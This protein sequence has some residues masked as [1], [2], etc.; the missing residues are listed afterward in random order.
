MT[1]TTDQTGAIALDGRRPAPEPGRAARLCRHLG[2]Q[3]R[4]R[5]RRRH[6]G[7][8]TMP[9]PC[10]PS[11]NTPRPRP[12]WKAPSP[13]I[14]TSMPL[15]AAY[16]KALADAGRPRE[17]M[18]VLARAHTP[19]KPDWSVLSA[20]GA[21]ADQLGDH[22]GRRQL[23]RG[24]VEDPAG[25]AQ[26]AVEPRPVLRAGQ[27]PA[28][29]EDIMKLAAADPRADM[30]VRQNYALV[31]SLEG[32]FK[33]A[34]GVAATDL[35]PGDAAASV[36]A[37]RQMIAS[38]ARWRGVGQGG[39]AR[40]PVRAARDRRRLSGA[41]RLRRAAGPA[42]VPPR[43]APA[44]GGTGAGGSSPR[45]GPRDRSATGLGSWRRKNASLRTWV[46]TVQFTTAPAG[47]N[48]TSPGPEAPR[49]HHAVVEHDRAFEDVDR[50]VDVVLPLELARRA[51][52]DQRAGGPVVAARQYRHCGRR[53]CPRRIQ[54][55]WIG[56]DFSSTDV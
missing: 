20:Q 7:R 15:L 39:P 53:G 3:A 32:K 48:T 19:D 28:R 30:R 49:R 23:L 42:W 13:S 44:D 2:P 12:C 26:R 16:G 14:P 29:A 36:D 52:P 25:R 17:A 21:V 56:A 47:K 40:V 50:L 22:A 27:G 18:D 5:P 43:R 9:A 10:A 6:G 1:D 24:G 31:L 4:R 45:A 46:S 41:I 34:E 11:P 38:D 33:Q 54:S 8:S 37:I 51:V 55:A 35:S